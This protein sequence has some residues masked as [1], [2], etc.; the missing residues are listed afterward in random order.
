[1]Y[2]YNVNFFSG[3]LTTSSLDLPENLPDD[4][5]ATS[6]YFSYKWI[7]VTIA[8]LC[9]FIVIISVI[10]VYKQF[11]RGQE[12]LQTMSTDDANYTPMQQDDISHDYN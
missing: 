8:L 12:T 11:K 10:V 5:T 3:I 9:F 2:N 6:S 1:M 7:F 4:F